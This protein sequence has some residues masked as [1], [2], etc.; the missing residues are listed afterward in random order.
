MINQPKYDSDPYQGYYRPCG[1]EV[2][3][4]SSTA[5]GPASMPAATRCA[6]VFFRLNTVRMSIISGLLPTASTLVS[7]ADGY[8]EI[9]SRPELDNLKL[10]RESADAEVH[11]FYY[12]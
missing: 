9:L 4:V 8:E 1:Y 5:V 6:R 2:L 12:S 11:F 10:I 3:A 7:M